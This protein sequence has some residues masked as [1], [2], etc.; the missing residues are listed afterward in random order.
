MKR[1]EDEK[2]IFFQSWHMLTVGSARKQFNFFYSNWT[3]TVQRRGG[4]AAAV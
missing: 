2:K 1:A 3:A 4:G